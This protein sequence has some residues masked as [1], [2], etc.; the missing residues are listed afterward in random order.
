MGPA[1]TELLGVPG[2]AV[3]W[4]LTAI[5][6]AL[7]GIRVTRYV[8]VLRRARPEKRWDRP[9]QRLGLFLGHVLGQKRM[10]QEPLIGA[11]HLAIFWSFLAFA[12]TFFWNLIRGLLPA[13]PVPYPDEIAAVSMTLDVAAVVGLAALL[14]AAY[15][16][17]VLK[18]ERLEQSRD[19]GV[20]LVLIAAVLVTQLAGW[21]WA[22]MVV[23]LGFLAYLPYSKH[24]HLLASP[25]GVFFASLQPGALAPVS[26]DNTFTWRELYNGL[27]CAECGRCDRACPV[28]QGGYDFSPKELVH[29]VKLVARG[30]ATLPPKT[31]YW[32][33]T[34]CL[35]CSEHCPVFNEH[36][37]LIV[38]MRRFALAAGEVEPALQETMKNLTRYGNSF[39]QSPRAR[40]KW[41]Q[42][43]DFKIKDARREPVEY[44]WFVGDYA[45]FDPRLQP[46]T[47][48]TARLLRQ[49]GL[50]F[51][52]LYE[53]EQNAGNDIRRTGEEGLFEMLRE[54]NQVALEKA[55]Y[56]RIVT[57][58]PHSYHALKHEYGKNGSVV[59]T[60]E[61]FDRLVQEGKL[62]P[63]RTLD[64]EATYQDPCY[65][66]RYNGIFDAP[67]R[68]LDAIGVTLVEMPRNRR[69]AWCC[70]AGGGR[71]WM[72]DTTAARERPA[73]ARVREAAAIGRAQVLVTTCPKDLIMFQDAL[74]TTGLE[75]QLKA[76]DIAELVEEAVRP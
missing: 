73:E 21:W 66:G 67:R 3:L 64:V 44:L 30:E 39:G 18:P 36:V 19:A 6:F 65:L 74:K 69:E 20:I 46:A 25:F 50:D 62:V 43:L 48:A 16:R 63:Q 45:S 35:A 54:K 51:G 15:R 47:R 10:L 22:H 53:S 60:S 57:T 13:L 59:H 24:M 71:I 55:E 33:C 31:D 58:D 72:E 17:Y 52:I 41:T 61:L 38:E 7:F 11:A 34:S 49:A 1:Q 70:G 68:L 42:G 27:A 56:S 29:R 28:H 40:A 75:A 12:I 32:V 5:S 9:L 8:R 23:V 76:K 14:V 2:Y 26:D 37:P 4:L